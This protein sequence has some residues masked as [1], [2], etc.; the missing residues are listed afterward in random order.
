MLEEGVLYWVKAIITDS[1]GLN[2][3]D[4]QNR[5]GFNCKVYRTYGLGEVGMCGGM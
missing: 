2:P 3:I 1:E 5:K 4:V